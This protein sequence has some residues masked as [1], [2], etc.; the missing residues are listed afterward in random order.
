MSTV[1]SGVWVGEVGG[2]KEG[3][4]GSS[5]RCNTPA[6]TTMEAIAEQI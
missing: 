4:A 1:L 6:E 5:G 2:V 3:E